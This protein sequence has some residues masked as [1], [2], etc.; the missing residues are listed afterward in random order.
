VP[1]PPLLVGGHEGSGLVVKLGSHVNN[2]KI[3]D[4]VGIKWTN[5]TCS[6][7]ELCLKGFESSCIN[8]IHTGFAR[9]GTF[10]AIIYLGSLI[11]VGS[12]FSKL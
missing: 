4:K 1:S 7:C 6:T 3:G 12:K 10:Q 11:K 2:F 5:A 8:A 9:N